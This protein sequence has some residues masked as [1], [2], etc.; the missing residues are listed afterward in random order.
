ML[1]PA[2]CFGSQASDLISE[3]GQHQSRGLLSF[4]PGL[5]SLASPFADLLLEAG[6][7]LGCRLALALG[8][9]ARSLC[10]LTLL[11]NL[12]EELAGFDGGRIKRPARS[13]ENDA[14]N[15]QAGGDLER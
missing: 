3:L 5:S 14:W 11:L 9:L 12:V 10:R 7:G 13:L 4:L 6:A 8:S 15:A 2:P 1:S